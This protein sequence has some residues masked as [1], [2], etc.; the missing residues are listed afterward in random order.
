MPS[1]YVGSTVKYRGVM[2]TLRECHRPKSDVARKKASIS[3]REKSSMPFS[4]VSSFS[5]DDIVCKQSR[6]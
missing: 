5:I 2:P 6:K 4:T 1:K 3:S